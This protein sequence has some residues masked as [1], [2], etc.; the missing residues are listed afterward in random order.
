M[1]QLQE[2]MDAMQH[3]LATIRGQRLAITRRLERLVERLVMPNQISFYACLL[4]WNYACTEA[5]LIALYLQW[6]PQR[7]G[8]VEGNAAVRAVFKRESV[9][10]WTGWYTSQKH[11]VRN[12]MDKWSCSNLIPS[13]HNVLPFC[14]G[15]DQ[16]LQEAE[17]SYALLWKKLVCI[18]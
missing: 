9:W 14:R 5:V 3:V 10:C 6:T 8:T 16:K 15:L 11:W 18:I 4:C 13:L 7:K 12:V 2:N 1:L 17:K